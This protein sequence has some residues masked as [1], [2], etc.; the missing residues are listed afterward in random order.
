MNLNRQV[1][2]PSKGKFLASCHFVSLFRNRFEL[3]TL[4]ERNLNCFGSAA[5]NRAA[6]WRAFWARL[7]LN[8]CDL[9]LRLEGDEGCVLAS[10][11]G[12][13]LAFRRPFSPS[14]ARFRLR[15][16][17]GVAELSTLNLARGSMTKMARWPLD[18]LCSWK[19]EK[20]RHTLLQ[21]SPVEQ[22]RSY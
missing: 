19:A 14:A 5:R 17:N 13:R 2:S 22:V 15:F 7:S 16:R 4:F 10:A 3:G 21:I 18:T 9:R 1:R 12:P 8:G 11:L 6:G 20:S